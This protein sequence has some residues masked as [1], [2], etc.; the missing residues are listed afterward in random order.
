MKALIVYSSKSGNTKKLAEVL[1]RELTCQRTLC[2]IDQ[3]PELDGYDLVAVGFW[4]QAGKP[5]PKSAGLLADIGKKKLFLFAT[6]GAAPDSAHAANAMAY[7]ASLAPEATLLGTFNCQGQVDPAF[8]E[9]ARNK[10][11]QP[12]WIGDAPAAEGHPD[13]ADLERL[14]QVVRAGL[15]E[16]IS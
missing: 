5:D 13:Q 11:P 14:A 3:V 2:G 16:F 15:P 8:L 7:A 6:H 10:D 9:K 12:P 4:L 1:D